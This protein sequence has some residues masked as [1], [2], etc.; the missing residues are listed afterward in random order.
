MEGNQRRRPKAKNR[1]IEESK[2]GIPLGI[3]L[4]VATERLGRESELERAA[5]DDRLER[6]TRERERR[7]QRQRKPFLLS[8]AL[9]RSEGEK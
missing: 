9:E 7:R 5:M 4:E 8:R 2:K 3:W 1:R 6:E